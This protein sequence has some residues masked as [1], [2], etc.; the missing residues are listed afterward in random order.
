LSS[1][2]SAISLVDAWHDTNGSS[3]SAAVRVAVV[4]GRDV[5]RVRRATLLGG[6]RALDHG[7][8]LS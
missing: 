4:G 2:H 7:A 5:R 8:A 6:D 1:S 3:C